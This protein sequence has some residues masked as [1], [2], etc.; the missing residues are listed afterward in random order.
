MSHGSIHYV[1]RSDRW[2]TVAANYHL[3]SILNIWRWGSRLSKGM[4]S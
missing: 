2:L 3:V 1:A 4:L